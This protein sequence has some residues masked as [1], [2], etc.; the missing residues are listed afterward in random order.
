MRGIAAVLLS[1]LATAQLSEAQGSGFL[2]ATTGLTWKLLPF[3]YVFFCVCVCECLVC[4][5]DLRTSIFHTFMQLRCSTA[6]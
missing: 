4:A 1:V 2:D 6:V 3:P 5:R